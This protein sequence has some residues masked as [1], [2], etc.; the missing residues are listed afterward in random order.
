MI[1]LK[2]AH[3]G[4]GN[5]PVT[6]LFAAGLPMQLPPTNT[7]A[8]HWPGRGRARGVRIN[9][10][11]RILATMKNDVSITGLGLITPLGLTAH[12]NWS[13]ICP[14]R[15]LAGAA[16]GPE[17]FKPTGVP[18]E[19]T[20]KLEVMDRG[21]IA[22]QHLQD[23]EALYRPHLRLDRL[24]GLTPDRVIRLALVAACQ[25]LEH[26]GWLSRT[27]DRPDTA[28]FVATSK[29]PV[30][31]SLEACRRLGQSGPAGVD[32]S[33]AWHVSHGPAAIAVAIAAAL[34][35]HVH[36][37]C[38]GA[39]AGALIATHRARQALVHGHC[40]RALVVAADA[41]LHPLF[42]SSFDNL[43]VLA[44]P[45]MDGHRRCHPF[46][47]QG[48][49]FF[50]SEGAA[51]ICLEKG[52]APGSL[53]LENSWTGADGTHLVGTDPRAGS[54]IGG[55]KTLSVPPP[56]NFVHAHAAGTRNDPIELAAIRHVFGPAPEVFSCK[57]WLGHSLGAAGLISL[58]LS[59]LCHEHRQTLTGHTLPAA[60]RSITI[61]Q[62]FGGHIA[63]CELKSNG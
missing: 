56:P 13:A 63:M 24:G 28:L 12:A 7:T 62:G 1:S 60:S 41:S 27:A 50:I 55:L 43:G 61:A 52:G 47:Q 19:K 57:Q 39:C 35:M 15:N 49:G 18:T 23:M 38:V 29:G 53:N 11:C 8:P 40:R 14:T 10:V 9:S 32:A 48:G 37:T 58:V 30:L 17:S 16:L 6:L 34:D 25:A 2:E 22:E 26:A 33:L 5:K 59:A 45:E 31:S 54:L 20:S 4:S 44:Q 51:A 46:A 42:E 21:V 3:I 36:T